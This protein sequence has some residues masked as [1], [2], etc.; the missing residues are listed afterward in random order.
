MIPRERTPEQHEAGVLRKWARHDN[1]MYWVER[2]G[3][4]CL[5]SPLY[6]EAETAALRSE[7]ARKLEIDPPAP[8]LGAIS[9]DEG[10]W[11]EIL[12]RSM[13]CGKCGSDDLREFEH[14]N[15]FGCEACLKPT[16]TVIGCLSCTHIRC[17]DCALKVRA[18]SQL[19]T[20][21]AIAKDIGRS[22]ERTRQIIEGALRKLRHPARSELLKPFVDWRVG[23][24]SP[25]PIVTEAP[26]S[27]PFTVEAP[28]SPTIAEKWLSA[29]SGSE[30]AC[31]NCGKA[32]EVL[33][34]CNNCGGQICQSCAG[35]RL[36][37]P[38]CWRYS[39]CLDRQYQNQQSGNGPR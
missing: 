5:Y 16:P 30:G 33:R 9:Q 25:D 15:W 37:V 2:Y 13:L 12:E 7:I 10:G 8:D 19:M 3:V 28:R 20:L 4:A 18:A 17:P 31:G 22:R 29:A 38:I 21:D 14:R 1:R 6:V 32:A 36:S 34:S 24:P 27:S 23:S 11:N 35:P 26:Q 39:I